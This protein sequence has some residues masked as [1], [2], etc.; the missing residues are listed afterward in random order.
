MTDKPLIPAGRYRH[1]KGHEYTVLGTARHSETLEELVVYRPE[2]GDRGLWVRP[3][4]MFAE[5]VNVAGQE[6]PRF[7]HLPGPDKNSGAGL[8]NVFGDLPPQLPQEIV[9]T[10]QS[11]ADVRIERI[12]SQGHASPDGFWYDQGEHEWVLVLAGAARL[13]FED[14]EIEM[15]A[16]EFLNIPAHHKHRVEWTT[17]EEPTVWLAV[18]Y[19]AA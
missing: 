2:Y 10:L 6:V 15:H 11:A 8:P 7:A 18:Y 16:G 14:R 9:Q 5:T 12:V 4:Q 17:P 19:K 3:R 1:Y 13:R